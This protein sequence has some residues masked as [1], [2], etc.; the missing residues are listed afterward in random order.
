MA[1]VSKWKAYD[2]QEKPDKAKILAE[3]FI[4]ENG[5]FDKLWD[6]YDKENGKAGMMDVMD[7]HQFVKKFISPPLSEETKDPL[8]QEGY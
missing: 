2:V 6:A 5:K 8:E 4:V 7:A 3:S 1:I